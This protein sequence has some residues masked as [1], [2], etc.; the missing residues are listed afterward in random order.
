MRDYALIELAH[1][2]RQFVL[3]V[4]VYG[5]DC[6]IIA[7]GIDLPTDPEAELVDG[8]WIVPLGVQQERAW[9]AVKAKREQLETGTA[10]T[11]LGARVQIDEASK[12]KIMGLL[13]MARLA[14]EA[15][16]PFAEQFTMADN[17]VVT[18]DN[19]GVR[20]LALAAGEYVSQVYARARALR[21]AIDAVETIEDL[22]AIDLEAGWP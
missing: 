18:L 6:T 19:A 12:A 21:A 10:P 22:D 14:E 2:E 16:Q 7:E 5:D 4:S 11:P 1:G 13:N 8:D 20:Q 3:D 15:E 9:S 17:S